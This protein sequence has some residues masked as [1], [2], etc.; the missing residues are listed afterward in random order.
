MLLWPAPS[1]RSNRFGA[2]VAATNSYRHALLSRKLAQRY[3]DTSVALA[4]SLGGEESAG[5]SFL[6]LD[7]T[8]W[9]TDKDGILLALFFYNLILWLSL[10]DSSHFWYMCHL[11]GFGLVAGQP[12][13]VEDPVRVAAEQGGQRCRD[14]G[15]RKTAGHRR[16]AEAERRNLQLA[17]TVAALAAYFRDAPPGDAAWA[18]FFLTG[19]RLKRVVDE[20]GRSPGDAMV[21]ALREKRPSD[22]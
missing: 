13:T 7:G 8:V 19:R 20:A 10:R 22:E 15:S 18:T 2:V 6:R 1:I 14:G 12:P 3:R 9:T 11:A 16:R 4:L 21:V 17:L 5:A